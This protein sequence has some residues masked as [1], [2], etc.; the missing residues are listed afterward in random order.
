MTSYMQVILLYN[1]DYVVFLSYGIILREFDHMFQDRSP[2][3]TKFLVCYRIRNF[4]SY[5]ILKHVMN[6]LV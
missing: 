5:V 2:N 4:L 3:L 1:D 6:I